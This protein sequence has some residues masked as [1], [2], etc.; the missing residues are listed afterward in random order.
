M[1]N[2]H[3]KR[4]VYQEV[5]DRVIA[6]LEKGTMPWHR[7]WR[8]AVNHHGEIFPSNALTGN[9]Y[10]GVNVLLLWLAAEEQGYCVNRW[11]TFRQAQQLGGS[12]RKGETSTL[13]VIYKPLEL[14]AEDKEGNLLFEDAGKPLMIQRSMLKANPLFNVA[15]CDGL[16]NYLLQSGE[17]I[18]GEEKTTVNADICNRV[19][20]MYQASGVNVNFFVQDRA[21]YSSSKDSI[22]MPS[23]E[24]FFTEAD[25]WSTLLHEMV[26]STG[27]STRLNREG[28]TSVSRK[29]G[30]PVY[31][32]EELIAEMGSAFLCAQLE[33]LGEVNHESY[34][35]HWLGVLK[36]DK[37]AL[38]RACKQAREASEF[39]LNL[40]VSDSAKAA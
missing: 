15:Q 21:Y 6:A 24:Q 19:T 28:I 23:C 12:V 18:P 40:T 3:V 4:D 25:Y 13:A 11:L 7:P 38:F 32:F 30:D 35:E 10:N 26:H 36:E 5:T 9:F 37:K 29:F 8:A 1:K 27:H 16:P 20:A 22:V 31:S 2:Q 17:A 14:Q 33:V 39:L 34:I